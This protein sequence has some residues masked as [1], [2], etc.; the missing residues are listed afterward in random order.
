MRY[1]QEIL[2]NNTIMSS[3]TYITFVVS[4]ER[5]GHVSTHRKTQGTTSMLIISLTYVL[6]TQAM[7]CVIFEMYVVS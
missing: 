3:L 6:V 7:L 4:K 5:A 2:V 1:E